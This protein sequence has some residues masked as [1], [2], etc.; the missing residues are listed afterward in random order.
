[1]GYWDRV[2]WA[3]FIPFIAFSRRKTA[4]E[5][6]DDVIPLRKY[7]IS[8]IP[9]RSQLTRYRQF[10]Y[11][12][13]LLSAVFSTIFSFTEYDGDKAGHLFIPLTW[14]AVVAV[15]LG[16]YIHSFEYSLQRWTPTGEVIAAKHKPPK[17]PWMFMDSYYWTNPR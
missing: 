6:L 3:R 9:T 14:T 11:F 17:V 12:P 4:L 16:A 8:P 15:F 1:M 7:Y 13:L 5:R 2:C 10:A